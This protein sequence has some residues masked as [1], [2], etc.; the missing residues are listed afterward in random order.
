[1]QDTKQAVT[2]NDRYRWWLLC[3]AA[4]SDGTLLMDRDL[5]C[6]I[7]RLYWSIKCPH[8]DRWPDVTVVAPYDLCSLT[9][10]LWNEWS[11]GY[12]ADIIACLI[13]Q[14][15]RCSMGSSINVVV[16]Q[17]RL[18]SHTEEF[19]VTVSFPHLDVIPRTVRQC[20][21]T[22]E[23]CIQKDGTLLYQWRPN[24][25]CGFCGYHIN[26]LSRMPVSTRLFCDRQCDKAFYDEFRGIE[27][28]DDRLQLIETESLYPLQPHT[29][30]F[31][32]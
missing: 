4:I 16:E 10:A 19:L 31:G 9:S 23:R 26:A 32:I 2:H 21:P 25:T 29:H 15:R 30:F 7:T 14:F 5:L 22:W 8:L 24:L 18:H 27:E 12:K 20:N 28:L 3:H 6:H 1:M 17:Q 11:N 13:L